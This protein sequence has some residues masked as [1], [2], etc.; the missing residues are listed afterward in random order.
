MKRTHQPERCLSGAQQA[1]NSMAVTVG[2]IYLATQSVVVTV[3]GTAAS[4]LLTAWA[5]WLAQC[6]NQVLTAEETR[7]SRHRMTPT[8][9]RKGFSRH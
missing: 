2:G 1:V 4:T 8:N 6:R 3:A 5:L 7:N 9:L